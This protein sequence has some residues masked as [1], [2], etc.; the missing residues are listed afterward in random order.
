MLLLSRGLIQGS[1]PVPALGV[2]GCCPLV[3]SAGVCGVPGVVFLLS[4]C[5]QGC[6]CPSCPPV[7]LLEQLV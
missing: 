2:L 5:F 7:L 3:P 6:P 4:L 1:G